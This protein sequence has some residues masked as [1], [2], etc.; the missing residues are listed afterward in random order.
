MM[1]RSVLVVL[2][3]GLVV[4]AADKTA[5][6]W[7]QQAGKE[8]AQRQFDAA[9]A[10]L[11]QCLKLEP[12]N[13]DAIDLR[14]AVAFMRG[15]F[16]ESVADFDRAIALRPDRANGHWRRGISLYYAGEYDKG[17]KQFEGY[18]KVDTNDVENA[19]WHW[20]CTLRKDGREAAR[21]R[22]LKIGKDRR[23]PMMEVYALLQGKKTPADVL[24]AA[25]A[26]ELSA[27]Q[28]KPRLF[29]AHLY[30][31]I[32]YDLHDQRDKAIEHLRLA[33]GKYH[34]GHYMGEVARVHLE[35]LEKAGR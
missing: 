16:K 6:D 5:A 2:L 25:N 14:G 10:S 7:L 4:E 8:F 20:M 22:L 34:I 29:Y 26:G 11:Q 17:A 12:N 23:V 28:R 30:L 15:Q 32:Y 24:A 27:E 18:E 33:A 3:A 9:A 35:V 13:A 19:F 31:G 1:Q 21:A